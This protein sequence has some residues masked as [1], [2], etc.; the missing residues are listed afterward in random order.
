M[1]KRIISGTGLLLVLA[2][3]VVAADDSVTTLSG[4]DVILPLTKIITS[5]RREQM[6]GVIGVNKDIGMLVKYHCLTSKEAKIKANKL[7]SDKKI[8]DVSIYRIPRDIMYVDKDKGPVYACES[9]Q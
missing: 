2:F 4:G 3:N 1:Y 5:P 8:R 6:Y 9:R 7:R